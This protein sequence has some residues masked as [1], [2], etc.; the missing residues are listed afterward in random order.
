MGSKFLTLLCGSYSPRKMESFLQKVYFF[1]L[2]M[3]YFLLLA[4]FW[5]S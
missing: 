2:H 5:L 3:Y 1:S 4:E